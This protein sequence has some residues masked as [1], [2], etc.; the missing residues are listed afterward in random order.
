MNTQRT[1]IRSK[2][3]IISNP[4]PTT[5]NSYIY[6]DESY[7]A[8]IGEAAK[9]HSIELDK[10][11]DVSYKILTC[12]LISK[13][14]QSSIPTTINLV[15]NYPLNIYNSTTKQQFEDFLKTPDLI[16]TYLNNNHKLFHIKN[17]LVFPQTLNTSKI[18]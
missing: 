14:L 13:S 11:N 10:T 4:I 6:K 8:I 3:E 17:C 2:V 7:Q 9:Q 5:S 16:H 15:I 18:K 12:S 1:T